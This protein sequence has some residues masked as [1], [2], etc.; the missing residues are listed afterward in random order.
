MK[1]DPWGIHQRW[2]EHGSG[3]YWDFCDFPLQDATEEEVANWP[4][5]SPDDY[6]LQPG[7]RELPAEGGVRR[8]RRWRR[9]G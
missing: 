3:G 9:D 4:M 5:P 7:G 6:R 2:V 1:V 8:P